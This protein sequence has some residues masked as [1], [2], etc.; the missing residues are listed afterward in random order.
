M[1][2]IR[3]FWKLI[4][5]LPFLVLGL[6]SCSSL[7]K[8]ES[9]V[10]AGK[11]KVKVLSTTAMIDNLVGEIGGERIEHSALIIGEIDPHGYEL[12]KGDDEKIE[13]ADIVFYNGLNL[14][15]GASLRYKILKHP[16]AVGVGDY[17]LKMF[18]EKILKVGEEI[19]PHI[20]MDISIWQETIDPILEALIVV[21][22]EGRIAYQENASK[23]REK[24]KLSHEKIL[25]WMQGLP[26]E[27]RFLVTSHD[28]FGYFAKRYLATEEERISGEWQK[29]FAAPEGLAPDGQ[30]SASDLH[31]IIEH[32]H[33][34][35][36]SVVFPE[37]NVSRDSLRKIVL[38]CKE[39]NAP[40][41]FSTDALYGDSMGGRGEAASSYLGMIE[42]NAMIL[43]KEWLTEET[44]ER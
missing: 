35:Q 40:I 43:M 23:L 36:I 11:A 38:A 1:K 34:H 15:H 16:K 12:V 29:R 30:L 22:P 24:M 7:G 20:W 5:I 21:D 2:K 39:K 4:F 3:A 6:T 9:Q 37:S 8:E 42:H 27:K 14:E 17:V 19:D 31:K 28:A 26:Q 25:G 41:R 13:A 32:L 33:S 44:H 18:P 10:P